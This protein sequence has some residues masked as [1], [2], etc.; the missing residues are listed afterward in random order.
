VQPRACG[1]CGV[2]EPCGCLTPVDG[3]ACTSDLDCANGLAC[4]LNCDDCPP[5]PPCVHGFCIY[6][7][8]ATPECICTGCA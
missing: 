4:G 5:C 3:L 1:L 8:D 2:E 6:P 7:V